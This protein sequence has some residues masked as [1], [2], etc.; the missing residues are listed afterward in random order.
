MPKYIR[1]EMGPSYNQYF[2]VN[3]KS[4][5][6]LAE[7]NYHKPWRR[8]VMDRVGRATVWSSDCLRDVAAF[9]EELN[10]K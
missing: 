4:H 10:R 3:I 1:F 7:I 6:I 2:V 5:D 9:L 8:L